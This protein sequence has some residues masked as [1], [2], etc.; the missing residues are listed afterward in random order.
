MELLCHRGLWTR[1]AD[2][3]T[4]GAFH[5]AWRRGWGVETDLRDRDGDVVVSHDPA[6]SGAL[7]LRHLLDEYVLH[8]GGTRLA[9]NVKADGLAPAVAAE[10]SRRGISNAFVFDMS[11]PDQLC[12]QQ[13]G[14]DTW[15]RWSDVETTPVLLERSGGVWLDAF[16]D[17]DWWSLDAVVA[18][19]RE[20][21]V[22]IVSPELH[23]RPHEP[24]WRRLA[25]L[26]GLLLC[27]DR[28]PDFE[29]SYP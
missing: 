22:C 1:P 11:V 2:Q 6:R 15:T 21:S 23:R 5:A 8:G 28:A 9:L 13:A 20:R 29:R 3:N 10:L 24:V 16:R 17:D 7:E 4:M 19:A 12:W 25:G 26:D 14:V 27:T 18:M